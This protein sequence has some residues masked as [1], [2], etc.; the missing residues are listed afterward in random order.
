MGPAITLP[1]FEGGRLRANLRGEAAGYDL[2]V[3]TY[4]RTVIGA[5]HDTA[6]QLASIDAVARQ[7]REQAQAGA[8]A[9]SAFDI[10]RQRYAA[11]LGTYLNV[12]TAETQVLVQR[13]QAVDL[14]ARALTTRVALAHALGGGYAGD[15]DGPLAQA[16]P[17]GPGPTG[18]H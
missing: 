1:V 13:R 6:D 15:P 17:A 14:T 9:Q 12:L 10:A 16:Q 2:A 7:Q 11:G 5:V 4:N 3:E 18:P 8:A